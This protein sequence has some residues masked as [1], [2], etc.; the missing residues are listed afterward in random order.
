MSGQAT[1]DE[2]ILMASS[3]QH[4]LQTRGRDCRAV[5]L[6]D[7]NT[8]LRLCGVRMAGLIEH[9]EFRLMV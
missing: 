2:H 7:A 4:T 8:D 5:I 3:L 1:M 6:R 9:F